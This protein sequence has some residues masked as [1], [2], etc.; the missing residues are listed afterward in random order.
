MI[1]L[2]NGITKHVDPTTFPNSSIKNF[3][4]QLLTQCCNNENYIMDVATKATT[5]TNLEACYS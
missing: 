2:W 4:S 3:Q 1:C 5:I